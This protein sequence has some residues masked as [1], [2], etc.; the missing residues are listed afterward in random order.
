MFKN[1]SGFELQNGYHKSYSIHG[2]E[3]RVDHSPT[4]VRVLGY[5]LNKKN[6]LSY[7]SR[8][9]ISCSSQ[10]PQEPGSGIWEGAK[11]AEFWDLYRG[12]T[13]GK[14]GL[15]SPALGTVASL[16]NEFKAAPGY[17]NWTPSCRVLGRSTSG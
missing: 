4:T 10:N 5:I 11:E 16:P 1:K 3:G 15:L 9:G 13:T 6:Q 8:K 17:S 14:P 7:L 12:H 2:E